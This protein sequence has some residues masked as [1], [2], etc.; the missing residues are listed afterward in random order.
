MR[1]SKAIVSYCI[2]DNTVVEFVEGTLPA[3]RA[4][5]VE[6]HIAVCQPCRLRVA[7]L[8]ASASRLADAPEPPVGVGA[9]LQ[10]QPG[11]RVDRFVVLK[12]L[13]HGGMGVVFS[14]I[15]PDLRRQVAI[16]LLRTGADNGPVRQSSDDLRDEARKMASLDHPNIVAVHETGTYRGEAYLVMELV[17]GTTL[18]DWLYRW[19]KRPWT[20]IV[21]GFVQAG[22]AL[23]HAHSHGLAHGDFKPENVLV[24]DT[25]RV[26]VTDFGLARPFEIRPPDAR[27][28][29]IVPNRAKND[30]AKNDCAKKDRPAMVMG[31]PRYMAPEQYRGQA[32]D[33]LSD[34][35]SFC[36][37]LFEA[38]Y[39]RH[40]CTHDNPRSLLQLPGEEAWTGIPRGTDVPAA[41]GRVLARGLH[42]RPSERYGS[43]D[44]LLAELQARR[45]FRRGRA[46]GLL[47]GA[48]VIAASVVSFAAGQ[49]VGQ[50]PAHVPENSRRSLDTVPVQPAAPGAV[51]MA[52]PAARSKSGFQPSDAADGQAGAGRLKRSEFLA[53]HGDSPSLS[54][55]KQVHA[56]LDEELDAAR[57]DI[58]RVRARMDHSDDGPDDGPLAAQLLKI[59]ERVDDLQRIH[60]VQDMRIARLEEGPTSR[61][62]QANAS[63]PNA[64]RANASR[65]NGLSRRQVKKRIES[66]FT[67]LRVCFK[68]WRERHPTGRGTLTLALAISRRGRTRIVSQR[69]LI[70]RVV[71]RCAA[72]ALSDIRF[73]RASRPSAVAVKLSSDARALRMRVRNRRRPASR[74]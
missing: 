63:R 68:E 62:S 22:R 54:L 45:Q 23:A 35:F 7:A 20:E 43:M 73:P 26:R 32:A 58:S 56:F 42:P 57:S 24:D 11:T 72:G 33:A 36:V 60:S 13:G 66:R 28:E 40:P 34:Q 48:L 8:G 52:A 12:R 30:G 21:D 74:R 19:G 61:S 39:E 9:H 71:R 59:A 16:K 27:D 31:T 37:A 15:D 47:A 41:I 29:A 46:L 44:E 64:G 70:D 69:G 55:L 5:N 1:R 51:A 14:A 25:D 50:E 65:P 38:L 53:D 17:D 10:L 6:R 67:D 49:R 18:G 2:G 3:G 4:S